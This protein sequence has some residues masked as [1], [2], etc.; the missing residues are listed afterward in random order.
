[1]DGD[2]DRQ[3]R[4]H[5]ANVRAGHFRNYCHFLFL[6]IGKCLHRSEVYD[7]PRGDILLAHLLARTR[8]IGD[9]NRL[10]LFEHHDET[11][12]LFGPELSNRLFVH[13]MEYF[14]ICNASIA[15]MVQ[16]ALHP[17]Q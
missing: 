11:T 8:S 15:I 12:N 5:V 4:W 9:D 10:H 1:M 14:W 16:L 6:W 3:F 13:R 17:E 2:I 7:G